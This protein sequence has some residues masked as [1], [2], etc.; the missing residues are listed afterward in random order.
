MTFFEYRFRSGS[1]VAA[2]AMFISNGKSFML[3]IL[4]WI[5]LLWRFAG[6]F[7][8]F[9]VGV[10]Y[11]RVWRF[12]SLSNG[13]SE[14]LSVWEQNRHT[15]DTHTKHSSRNTGENTSCARK[16]SWILLSPCAGQQT[17]AK[18]DY[19]RL[20]RISMPASKYTLHSAYT[21]NTANFTSS[22]S[23]SFRFS[24]WNAVSVS[25]MVSMCAHAPALRSDIFS[26]FDFRMLYLYANKNTRWSVNKNT[27]NND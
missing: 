19:D 12:V 5:A 4:L 14:W 27:H 20:A 2:T 3:Y 10:I 7:R 24:L 15:H 25:C 9:L 6:P 21:R 26:I 17:K 8:V 1:I 23:S 18:K 11:S 16:V 22:S 13:K